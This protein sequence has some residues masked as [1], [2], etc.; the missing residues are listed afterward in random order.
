[1]Q[2]I[3]HLDKAEL[4][5]RGLS[6]TPFEIAQQPKLW[7]ELLPALTDFVARLKD[8]WS[9]DRPVVLVGAG[10]SAFAA[11]AVAS[12]LKKQGLPRA[13]AVASTELILDPAALLPREPF[14]MISFARSG[15][16][17]E[18]NAAFTLASALQP[19]TRHIVITCNPAGE[20]AR[21]AREAGEE[22]A[23]LFVL[24]DKAD[25]RGLAMTS[26]FTGMV[27]VGQA[28]GYVDDPR[29][30]AHYV[31]HLARSAESI[32]QDH[33]DAI[34][35]L[36]ALPFER[37][38]FI[39][40]NSH[41][42]TALE[43]HL[44]VQELSNGHVVA[45]AESLLGIRHGPM[46]VIDEKTLVCVFLSRDAYVQSYEMDLL[47]ELREKGLGMTTVVCLPPHSSDGGRPSQ[48]PGA[49][50][51]Q[52]AD[53][54]IPIGCVADE[55]TTKECSPAARSVPPDHLWVAPAVLVGQIL[56]LIK[57]VALGLTP[58][59][60]SSDDVISRVVKGVNIYPYSGAQGTGGDT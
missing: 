40:A 24:P 18:G 5:A 37:A 29:L 17:P 36:A 26:S 14:T 43:S 59:A 28:L 3:L 55:A 4:D 56:G 15:N 58:D 34:S 30:F 2:R 33:S 1:M 19:D 8:F 53:V 39:G 42:A 38:V 32:L 46:T 54:V 51:A 31:G 45:K 41:Y 11:Q 9:E 20:L 25:D 49:E 10:T 35:R 12:T 50:L 21:L 16:S 47:R 7:L 23:R 44:K 48:L 13:E 22:R 60:P 6:H 57:S 52:V 27:I